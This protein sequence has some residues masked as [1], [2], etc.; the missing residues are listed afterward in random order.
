MLLLLLPAALAAAVVAVH[1]I[2]VLSVAVAA[3]A[4]A[5]VCT[6]RVGVPETPISVH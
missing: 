1:G 4:S 3:G 6:G 2:A 5:G